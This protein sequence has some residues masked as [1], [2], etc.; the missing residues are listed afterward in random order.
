[1][2]YQIA[3]SA[4]G[5]LDRI[6]ANILQKHLGTIRLPGDMTPEKA[7]GALALATG[8]LVRDGDVGDGRNPPY[9][10]VHRAFAEFL[11]AEQ[12]EI[13]ADLVKG[14]LGSHLHLEPAWY[15]VWILAASLAPKSV[16]SQLVSLQSDP[17]H[18]A[19]SL[20]AM[21]I[22]EL[23]A[24]TRDAP[25]VSEC[26]DATV[27]KCTS[28]LRPEA[29]RAVRRT[30]IDALI[31]IGGPAA[32]EALAAVVDEPNGVGEAAAIALATGGGPAGLAALRKL[33]LDPGVGGE[34]PKPG[35]AW[36]EYLPSGHRDV[37]QHRIA[38]GLSL[39]GRESVE[40]LCG[41]VKDVD[42]E[43]RLRKMLMRVLSRGDQSSA[44]LI[45]ALDSVAT[46]PHDDVEVRQTAVR[47]L[48]YFGRQATATLRQVVDD[49]D[50]LASLRQPATEA[51]ESQHDITADD[52]DNEAD[53]AGGLTDRDVASGPEP[54]T[55]CDS[56]ETTSSA[57]EDVLSHL[58]EIDSVTLW[59][60]ARATLDNGDEGAV[61]VLCELLTR[62]DVPIRMYV[63]R[64]L[65]RLA[66]QAGEPAA[67]ALKRAL[68]DPSAD[69]DF[70][71]E[72]VQALA[73]ILS[74]DDLNA[75]IQ[76]GVK[77]SSMAHLAGSVYTHYRTESCPRKSR[78]PLLTAL[79]KVTTLVE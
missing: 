61:P 2:A 35:A 30:A 76:D 58:E 1:M 40:M 4:D 11:V 44:A 47:K 69:R 57:R 48:R 67:E 66:K 25:E 32:I 62:K 12:L 27:V 16:L 22:A 73:N 36:E 8:V 71:D 43:P 19:L 79:T 17:L 15:Q 64:E 14:C 63:A 7:M 45:S 28:L 13:E 50:A 3:T 41:I 56:G 74:S 37:F 9:L 75:W 55:T 77:H 21:A 54:D 60:V 23:D 6:P 38:M 52:E 18:I 53:D 78:P 49:V 72:G 24:D 42:R 20:A 29:D 26:V 39:S 33:L 10:F 59:S 31:L 5:W 34:K 68:E 51:V 65:G 70:L 46:D